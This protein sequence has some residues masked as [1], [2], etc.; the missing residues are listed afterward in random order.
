MIKLTK[1]EQEQ[2][3]Y[4]FERGFDYN[5][6]IQLVD[7]LEKRKENEELLNFVKFYLQG[8]YIHKVDNKEISD[9]DYTENWEH[10]LAIRDFVLEVYGIG[11]IVK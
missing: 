8:Y 4:D 10:Y 9:K 6:L 5:A 3:H 1:K 11:A 2:L 7:I